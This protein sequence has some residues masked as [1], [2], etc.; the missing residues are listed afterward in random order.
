MTCEIGRRKLRKCWFSSGRNLRKHIAA[1][2]FVSWQREESLPNP[3]PLRARRCLVRSK[4]QAAGLSPDSRSSATGSVMP[5]ASDLAISHRL[6]AGSSFRVAIR[7]WSY[8]C[9]RP[10]LHLLCRASRAWP[11]KITPVSS[12]NKPVSQSAVLSW[13]DNWYELPSCEINKR[14]R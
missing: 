13:I 9:C 4:L 7:T 6:R 5:I 11:S 8:F 3:N 2:I 12:L 14:S 1:V 10:V